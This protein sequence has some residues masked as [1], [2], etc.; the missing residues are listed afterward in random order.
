MNKQK[1]PYN[2]P[3]IVFENFITGVEQAK[4]TSSA[5]QTASSRLSALDALIFSIISGVPVSTRGG[6]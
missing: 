4:F 1:K 5:G 6:N 2:K 3:G